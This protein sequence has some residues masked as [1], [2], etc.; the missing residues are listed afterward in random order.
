VAGEW[1][2]LAITLNRAAHAN[3]PQSRLTIP[4]VAVTAASWSCAMPSWILFR[5]TIPEVAVTAA[6]SS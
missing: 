3:P 4:E 2:K 5:L 1:K 6:A